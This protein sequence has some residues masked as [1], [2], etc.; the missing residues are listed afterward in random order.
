[1]TDFKTMTL[2]EKLGGAPAVEAAVDK[3]Y[4]KVLNDE[5]VKHFFDN[6]DMKRQRSHQKAFLTYA[7]G[8]T[9]SYNGRGMRAAHKD[10]VENLHLSD[11]HFNAIAENLAQTLQEMNVEEHLIQEALQIVETTRGDVLNR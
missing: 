5:R 3:F 11:D 4:D 10:L 7:L 9:K 6:T 2:Y 8:G 1:M